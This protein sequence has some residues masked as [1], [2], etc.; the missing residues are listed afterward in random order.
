[1][2]RKGDLTGEGSLGDGDGGGVVFVLTVVVL[3]P[4]V[5]RQTSQWGVA[6]SPLS[7]VLAKEI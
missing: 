2:A 4:L 6:A 1:M 5:W 3:G 7:W